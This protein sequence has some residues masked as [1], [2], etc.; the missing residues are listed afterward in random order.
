MPVPRLQWSLR[1]LTRILRVVVALVVVAALAGVPTASGA[2]S[3]RGTISELEVVS[4]ATGTLTLR[5]I[6]PVDSPDHGGV[7]SDYRISWALEG[8]NFATWTDL[9]RNAFPAAPLS[10]YTITGLDPGAAYKVR[11]RTRYNRGVSAAARWSGRWV[12]AAPV[13]AAPLL[14]A[15]PGDDG[16]VDDSATE[17]GSADAGLAKNSLELN[18]RQ[19]VTNSAPVFA[20]DGLAWSV[21]ENTVAGIVGEIA[22]T[23]TDLGDTLVYSVG[24]TGESDAALHLTAFQ[25]HFDLNTE[26]GQISVKPGAMFD[27]GT[28]PSYKVLYQVSDG[29]N[30]T[31]GSDP[32]ID[33]TIT[34]TITVTSV[35]EPG[36]VSFSADPTQGTT[37]TATLADPD[38]VSGTPSWIWERSARP[39]SGFEPIDGETGA[40]YTP[41]VADSAFFLRAT[42]SYDDGL[43]AG[44]TASGVTV[45]PVDVTAGTLVKNTGRFGLRSG[46]DENVLFSFRTGSNSAGYGLSRI[47]LK[48]TWGSVTSPGPV[49]ITTRGR[50]RSEANTVATLEAPA[51]LVAGRVNYFTVPA[52]VMLRA[53][54]E[55]LL[56]LGNATSVRMTN[57]GYADRGGADGWELLQ[58]LRPEV[59]SGVDQ[60]VPQV[61]FEGFELS[62][63]PGAS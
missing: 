48:M 14:S 19:T 50:G 28:R 39:D 23:D 6:P 61:E 63:S 56:S 21:P 43:G 57:P 38:V 35:D 41:V 32:A 58:R 36:T 22:A 55:Y 11:M 53:D 9:G 4:E 62:D 40:S 26:R 8:E 52:G 2:Q 34:L 25:L 44:K 7:L 16:D 1:M 51:L 59:R 27:L 18:T 31:D 49:K 5:W 29:K 20:E 24:P 30:A 37:L 15:E 3:A 46:I 60:R 42:A 33:D 54:T 12:E 47:G 17:H 10:E 45:L 13:A